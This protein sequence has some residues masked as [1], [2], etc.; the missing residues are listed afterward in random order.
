MNDFDGKMSKRKQS[1]WSEKLKKKKRRNV[2]QNWIAQTCMHAY[3]IHIFRVMFDHNLFTITLHWT[4]WY[5]LTTDI[6]DRVLPLRVLYECKLHIHS[7]S[8]AAVTA[9]VCKIKTHSIWKWPW[10]HFW[11]FES[12]CFY[13]YFGKAN[14]IQF[15]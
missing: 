8:G 7:I 10:S 15:V 1:E 5:Q 4:A 9:A 11:L 12:F 6:Q 3:N 13:F 14:H 2:F